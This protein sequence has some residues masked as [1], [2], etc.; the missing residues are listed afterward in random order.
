M[1]LFLRRVD[2]FKEGDLEDDPIGII[3]SVAVSKVELR[4]IPKGHD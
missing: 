2:H 1:Q 4:Q 3:L